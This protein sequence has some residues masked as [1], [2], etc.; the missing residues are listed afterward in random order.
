[1]VWCRE[2]QKYA[3]INYAEL[4]ND[5]IFRLHYKPDLIPYRHEAYRLENIQKINIQNSYFES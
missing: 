1:M 5:Q 4:A 2:W 3:F